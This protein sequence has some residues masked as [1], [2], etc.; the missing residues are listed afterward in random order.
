MSRV[1]GEGGE[2]DS[3]ERGEGK[4]GNG[5]QGGRRVEEEG[6]SSHACP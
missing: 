2:G 1:Q 4:R 3:P 5:L 6:R